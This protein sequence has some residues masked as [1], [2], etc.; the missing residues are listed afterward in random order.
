MR[1]LPWLLFNE[2]RRKL[3]YPVVILLFEI[4]DPYIGLPQALL[5]TI[6]YF[7]KSFKAKTINQSSCYDWATFAS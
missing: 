2:K 7:I 6:P 1:G 3:A 4:G 5:F